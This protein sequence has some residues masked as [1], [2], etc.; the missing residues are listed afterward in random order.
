MHWISKNMTDLHLESLDKYRLEIFKQLRR[1]SSLGVL[2]GGTA[3]ALQI[4]HR[5]SYDFDIFTHKPL[6]K[7]LFRKLKTI[8]GG[9]VLKTYES[10]V[11]LN[12]TVGENV[13]VTFYY[14]GYGP[15][16]DTIK[17]DGIDLLDLGDLASN[18]ALTL[19]GRGQWRDYVDIYF[20]IKEK[21]V[22]LESVIDMAENRF[23]GEFSRKL[24]LEQLTYTDD[25][26]KFEIEF[27]RD[28]VVPGEID[29][30]FEEQVK[31]YTQKQILVGT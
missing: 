26:G 23:G 9:G 7:G 22:R 27:L 3:I 25:L 6:E 28:E 1:F 11:Q 13:K 4:G 29:A 18:K 17:T 5:K 30:F 10:K 8:F 21:W 15:S 24:F 14:D 2:A 31:A 12:V 20:L 19:G 16:L